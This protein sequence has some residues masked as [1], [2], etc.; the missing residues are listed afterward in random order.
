MLKEAKII[1]LDEITS[2]LDS[3]NENNIMNILRELRVKHPETTIIMVTHRLHLNNFTDK[4][5]LITKDGKIEEG[6]HKELL[7][8]ENSNYY[9]LWKKFCEKVNYF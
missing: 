6:K 9:D 3:A 5:I 4:V 1:L 8:Q 7:K 2:S